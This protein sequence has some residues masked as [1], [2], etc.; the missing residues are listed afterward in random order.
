MAIVGC[1]LAAGLI[2][3]A[4]AGAMAPIGKS[5]S[6]RVLIATVVMTIASFCFLITL[7]GAPWRWSSPQWMALPVLGVTFGGI[8]GVWW[9]KI[10]V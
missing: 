4:I 10:N 3:G 7:Y 9:G 2:G 6:G 1:Y 8:F 5:V